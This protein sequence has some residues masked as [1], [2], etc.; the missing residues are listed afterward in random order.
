[1]TALSHTETIPR[2]VMPAPAT[3]TPT[4]D[5]QRRSNQVH[6][7]YPVP[8]PVRLEPWSRFLRREAR[9]VVRRMRGKQ[10]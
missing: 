2:V 3:T 7:E 8:P 5:T 4:G 9:S 10:G 1:M 6:F